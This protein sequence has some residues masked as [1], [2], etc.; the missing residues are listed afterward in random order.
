[1]RKR[2]GRAP[3]PLAERFWEKVD[4]RGADDCWIWIGSVDTRGYENLGAD[5]GRPMLRAHR[6]SYE[7]NVGPI[8]AGLVVC[9][10]C[11]VR[12]CVNSAH[13]F[14]ATQRDNVLD[15]LRKGRNNHPKGERHQRA[16]LTDAL[17]RAIRCD[18]RAVKEICAEY[19]IGR[20]TLY[21][22]RQ[23]K[24]WRHVP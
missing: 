24:T 19:R 12:K 16:K 8:P 20:S 10:Q 7:I 11:D 22:I 17:V 14:V 23:R 9:H 5:G 13:L 15:M 2:K 21:S 18:T 4:R 1:M 6:I 3:R